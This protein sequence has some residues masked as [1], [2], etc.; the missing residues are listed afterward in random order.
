MN[1]RTTVPRSPTACPWPLAPV[2]T[3]AGAVPPYF[4]GLLPESRRLT[5]LQRAIK[6]SAD[7]EFSLLLAIGHDA[8]GDVQVVARDGTPWAEER[9]EPAER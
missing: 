7:D 6:T 8:I 2:R 9:R 1:P 5:A 3:A 4:A